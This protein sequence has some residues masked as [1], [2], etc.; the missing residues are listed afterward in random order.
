[1]RDELE[2]DDLPAGL[3]GEYERLTASVASRES[4]PVDSLP[5]PPRARS[6]LL[7]ADVA[8][9]GDVARMRDDELAAL[10]GIGGGYLLELRAATARRGRFD[11][12]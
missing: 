2:R 8:T 4:M 3:R 12:A 1:M 11:R 7:R 9:V 6:A 10:P 5:L